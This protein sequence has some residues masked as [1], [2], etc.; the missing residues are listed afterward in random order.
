MVRTVEENDGEIINDTLIEIAKRHGG[1][2]NITAT[3]IY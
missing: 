2:D 1:H 3:V